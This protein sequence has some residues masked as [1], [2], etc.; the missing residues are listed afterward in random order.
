MIWEINGFKIDHHKTAVTD[1]FDDQQISDIYNL[2]ISKL[3]K[4]TT[5][6]RR[7]KVFDNTRRATSDAVRR[8]KN[9]RE[10]ANIIHNDYTEFSATKRVR[11]LCSE[12]ADSL[13]QNRFAIINVWQS[14]AGTVE[15][16]PL[17]MCDASSVQHKDLVAV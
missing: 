2:E 17:A 14:I 4:H 11:E 3:V 9:M 8:I 13:L 12:N 7:V 5:G 16:F 6:A 1:F 10:P 15:N